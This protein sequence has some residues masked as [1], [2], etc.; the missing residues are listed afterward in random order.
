[1]RRSL[2]TDKETNCLTTAVLVWFLCKKIS[3]DYIPEISKTTSLDEGACRGTVLHIYFDYIV[4][5][6]GTYIIYLL[7]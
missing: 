7:N 1:M 5:T 4:V 3:L 6:S 2:S